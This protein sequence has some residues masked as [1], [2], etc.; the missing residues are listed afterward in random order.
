[1]PNASD[2]TRREIWWQL[3]TDSH[4]FPHGQKVIGKVQTHSPTRQNERHKM[5]VSTLHFMSY[6]GGHVKWNVRFYDAWLLASVIPTISLSSFQN[7]KIN[8]WVSV[9][10][11]APIFYSSTLLHIQEFNDPGSLTFI[12]LT[13]EGADFSD[14]FEAGMCGVVEME[15]IILHY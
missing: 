2:T 3:N 15:A 7:T 1:M 11:E 10:P 8:I 4:H 13:T 12:W 6:S 5:A 14:M 9:V